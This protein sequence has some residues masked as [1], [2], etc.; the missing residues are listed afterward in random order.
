[1]IGSADNLIT[2]TLPTIL[3]TLSF[4]AFASCSIYI[5]KHNKSIIRDT[6][7]YFERKRRLAGEAK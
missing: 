3:F 5:S 2:E 4:V 6:N 1:M 7:N